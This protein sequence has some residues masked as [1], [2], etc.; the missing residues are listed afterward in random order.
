MPV[1]VT[2]EY[3]TAKLTPLLVPHMFDLAKFYIF[4]HFFSAWDRG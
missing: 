4:P 3:G 2:G 1:T